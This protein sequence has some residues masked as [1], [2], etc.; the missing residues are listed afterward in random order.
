MKPKMTIKEYQEYL[1]FKKR[2]EI[3]KKNDRKLLTTYLPAFIV[4]DLLTFFSGG[5]D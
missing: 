4:L 5:F 2:Q 1:E 3:E